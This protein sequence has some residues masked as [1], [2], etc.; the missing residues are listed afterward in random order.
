MNAQK[1]PTFM[2]QRK[3]PS[4]FVDR[5]HL[6]II[7]TI[8]VAYS[9]GVEAGEY[10]TSVTIVIFPPRELTSSACCAFLSSFCR[11]LQ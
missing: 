6:T 5:T 2:P 4:H 11:A 8:H 10:S 1:A 9:S 7:V 3:F